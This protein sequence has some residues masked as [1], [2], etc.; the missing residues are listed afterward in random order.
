MNLQLEGSPAQWRDPT[1]SPY[2]LSTNLQTL[3]KSL[4]LVLTIGMRRNI[5]SLLRRQRSR[6]LMMTLRL[7]Q[8]QTCLSVNKCWALSYT[9]RGSTPLWSYVNWSEVRFGF[10]AYVR[11]ESRVKLL[12]SLFSCLI[13]D[14]YLS[15]LSQPQSAE[16]QEQLLSCLSNDTSNWEP[17]DKKVIYNIQYAKCSISYK[18]ADSRW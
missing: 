12:C 6:M 18:C 3:W 16:M 1:Q 4:T 9:A 7:S 15:S 17:W 5:R 8:S 14:F 2:M 10:S 13:A 11:V